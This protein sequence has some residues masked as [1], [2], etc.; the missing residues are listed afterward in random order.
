MTIVQA[1]YT[2]RKTLYVVTE[3]GER[4]VYRNLPNLPRQA[5]TLYPL[6]VTEREYMLHS[7]MSWE[8]R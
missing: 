6:E 4:R 7:A 1:V 8:T 2:P 5:V 3:D